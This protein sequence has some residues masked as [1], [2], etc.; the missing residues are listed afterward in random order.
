M[1]DKYRAT[2][3]A[4]DRIG[5]LIEEAKS[6]YDAKLAKLK[7][8]TKIIGG[9]VVRRIEKMT[10]DDD[11]YCV[12]VCS[13]GNI[14]F[15]GNGEDVVNEITEMILSDADIKSLLGGHLNV[16][17]SRYVGCDT[18]RY[19]DFY[20]LHVVIKYSTMKIYVTTS[21]PLPIADV[22]NCTIEE[23]VTVRKVLKCNV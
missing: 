5:R 14:M 7:I 3:L 19:K 11:N 20:D 8:A 18:G 12:A 17:R 4:Q 10:G 1:E 2:G 6:D 9:Q 15:S 13:D 21:S 23:E 16:S 22:P